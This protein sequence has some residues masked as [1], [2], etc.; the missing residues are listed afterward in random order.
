LLS[1][2]EGAELPMCAVAFIKLV[3]DGNDAILAV[4]PRGAVEAVNEVDALAAASLNWLQFLRLI[5]ASA[6]GQSKIS[7]DVIAEKAVHIRRL[8]ASARMARSVIEEAMLITTTS[9]NSNDLVASS[10]SHRD[11]LSSNFS[12]TTSSSPSTPSE[13]SRT[14]ERT[15]GSAT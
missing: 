5:A 11:S 14:I 9:M 2:A 1:S 13:D 12:S 7:G 4:V 15:K 8:L 3:F 10:P 6:K